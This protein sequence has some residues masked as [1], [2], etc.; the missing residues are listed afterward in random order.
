MADNDKGLYLPLRINLSD[1]EKSLATADAD[2]QKAMREMRSSVSDLR[3]RY[4]VEIAG[5]KAAG[6]DARVLQLENA[7]L[8]S[9]YDAQ[10]KAVEALNNAYRKSVAEKGAD[11]KASQALAQQLVRESRQLERIQSQ[12]DAKGLNLGKRISDGLAGASPAFAKIRETVQGI[13]SGLSGMGA[14][15]TTAAKAIGGIG[16]AVAGFAAVGAGLQK[17]T[18][19]INDTAKAGLAASDNVYQLRESI[20]GTYEDAEFLRNVTAIDGSNAEGLNNALLR[21]I[22]TLKKDT[23]GTNSATVA[24]SK[25]GA[26]LLDAQGNAKSMREMLLQLSYASQNAAKAGQFQDFKAA[27]PGAFRTTEFDHLLL[28]LE[29]YIEKAESATTNTKILYDALHEVG[30]LQN[31]LDLARRQREG[32]VGSMFA[33]ATQE[34][35]RHE[36]ENARAINAILAENSGKYT[37]IADKIGT[38]TTAWVDFRDA[39]SLVWEDIKGDIASAVLE[40]SGFKDLLVQTIDEMSPERAMRNPFTFLLKTARNKYL[41]ASNAISDTRDQNAE[42][43]ELAEMERAEEKL[44]IQS[45]QKQERAD[46]EAARK[47]TE[48]MEKFNRELRDLRATDYERELNQLNDRVE[49]WRAAQIEETAIAER[50][51]LEKSAIDKR[52]FDKQQAELKKQTQAA[53]AEYAK[54]V[55]S[56]KR[57]RESSISDAESTLRNNLKLMRYIRSEQE[58]GTYTDDRAREYANRLYLR[59]NGFRQSDIAA[60]RDFG[61]DRLKDLGS[62]RDRVFA[63]FAPADFAPTTNNITITNNFDGTVVEDVTAMD[64]LANKVAEIITPA[65]QQALKGGTQYGY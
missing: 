18:N 60:L 36:I 3:L 27:L 7:K 28:G 55:E 46:A 38:I 40:L 42:V 6:N 12:I 56:A 64:K 13:T 21:L 29:G 51:A 20:Q 25:W 37:E 24:L 15:A 62:A 35:L 63:D 34:N 11:A 48:A 57:A 50:Y 26:Q 22:A 59:Q 31:A 9:I 14:T 2:L 41:S 33:N 61:V 49:A 17:L 23:D 5:A 52:Y 16:L 43:K 45:Q 8:N 47:R 1:W 10:K 4:D 65:I 32:I 58:K 19:Y 54:Q 30:D 39:S 53:Q 44:R